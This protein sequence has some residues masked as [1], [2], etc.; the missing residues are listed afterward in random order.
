MPMN[1]QSAGCL[2]ARSTK[3]DS[4]QM[5]RFDPDGKDILA[6]LPLNPGASYDRRNNLLW[7]GGYFLGWGTAQPSIGAPYFNF[8]LVPFDPASRDPLSAPPLQHGQW[9]KK[10][11]WGMLPDFGNPEGSRN[12]YDTG[13]ELTLIPLGT[14]LMN[15]I[16]TAGRGT[17]AVWNF[18]PC[19]TAPGTV[20]P[21]AGN[22]SYTPQGAFRDMQLGDELIPLNGYVLD[23]R[24]TTGEFRLWSFDPQARMPLAHPAVQQGRWTTITSDHEL[25][26][27]G[28]YV[29]D[30]VPSDRSYRLWLFDPASADPLTGP[31]RTGTLPDGITADSRL[32]GFEP[33]VPVAA[34]RASIPGTIEFMRTRIKHVVYYMLENRSF[35]HIV[36]WLHDKDDIGL[37]V[38]GPPGPYKG[39][40]TELFNLDG[41]EKVGLSLYK[42]GKLS[43]D[44]P[45]ELFTFD[46]YHDLSDT[47]RQL[48]FANRNGYAERAEPDMGGFIWNNG[49]R[50]VMQTYSPEQLPVLNGLA[51][52]FAI[53]DEWFCSIPSSTDANRA[54]S[55]TGSA[56]ME[57]SNFMSPP[58]YPVLAGTAASSAH[59]QAALDERLHQLAHLQLD[60]LDR[61]RVHVSALPRGAHPD[62]RRQREGRPDPV[63]RGHRSVLPGRARADS[64]R[65]SATWS[66]SGSAAAARRRTTPA[67]I[68]CPPR[69]S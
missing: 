14:F 32:L 22:Y 25:V 57:S 68:W 30:W 63:H 56:M 44:Y 52:H 31:V 43:T 39:A 4:Y 20:D 10:K 23:R 66:R 51:R 59:L 6:P 13:E 16:P 69:S 53:S 19:P 36:G 38:I 49:S 33:T 62:G 65:R 17:F 47:L 15:L 46:P 21:V 26:P 7:I 5:W 11:F 8:Q 18:D 29:L 54:F 50:Q 28:N 40:S 58:Q 67:R 64:F 42:D 61:P 55:L 34:D 45:L 41:D 48:F 1:P 9:S 60:G 35:D 24:R 3:S 2:V 27:I 37:R 12:Q